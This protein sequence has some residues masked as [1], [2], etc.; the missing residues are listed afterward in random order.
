MF[1]I[2]KR[3]LLP[4]LPKIAEFSKVYLP[5]MAG[6]VK[7]VISKPVIYPVGIS[8]LVITGAFP[9]YTDGT[10]HK[11][12]DFACEKNSM[13][14]AICS[15]TVTHATTGKKGNPNP[16]QVWVRT[17]SDWIG[18]KHCLPSVKASQVVKAGDVVGYADLS[19]KTTGYHLHFETQDPDGK[20]IEPTQNLHKYQPKL[21]YKIMDTKKYHEKIKAIFRE[22]SSHPVIKN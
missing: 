10:K 18:Y 11:G 15:G 14:R 21:R 8:P 5:K 19:G 9:K 1:E 3:L 16:S 22:D 12:V 4:I 20:I 7:D 13:I 6:A 17:A 2:L